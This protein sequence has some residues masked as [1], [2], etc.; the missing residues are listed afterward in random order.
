MTSQ[1]AL[2]RLVEKD[3]RGEEVYRVGGPRLRQIAI[4]SG[5]LGLEIHCRETDEKKS[6]V[7]CPVCGQ[8]LTRVRNMTVFGGTVTLGYRCSRCGYWT[9]LKKRVPTRYI[10]TRRG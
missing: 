3:L 1:R 10:F 6:M 7:K 4:D 8:R 9:G 5:R 2:K